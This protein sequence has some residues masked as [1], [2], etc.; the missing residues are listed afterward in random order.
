MLC[1][2]VSV[3]TVE[4]R[5]KLSQDFFYYHCPDVVFGNMEIFK[6]DPNGFSDYLLLLKY[7]SGIRKNGELQGVNNFVNH[8]R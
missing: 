8:A 7:K 2:E 4:Q 5:Q 6:D 3:Q 1:K